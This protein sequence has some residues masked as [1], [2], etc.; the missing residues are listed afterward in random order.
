MSQ[1][2]P[3]DKLDDEQGGRVAISSIELEHIKQLEW[4]VWFFEAKLGSLREG[5][6][7]NLENYLV[8]FVFHSNARLGKGILGISRL[9]NLKGGGGRMRISTREEIE[10]LQ[11]A[12]SRDLRALAYDPSSPG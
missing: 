6:W 8:S 12:L 10:K 3:R 7:I 9:I 2:L 4:A 5:D 11:E 1:G